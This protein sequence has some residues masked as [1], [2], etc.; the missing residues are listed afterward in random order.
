MQ[1]IAQSKPESLRGVESPTLNRHLGFL[2]QLLEFAPAQG[3]VIDQNLTTR[4]LRARSPIDRRDRDARAAMTA[5]Q[6][7]AHFAAPCFT[8]CLGWDRPTVPGPHIYH[9]AVYWVP[10]LTYYSGARLCLRSDLCPAAI[11]E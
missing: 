3:V 8:G 11:D 4:G 6:D 7:K 9:R 2:K 5:A 10:M 1:E